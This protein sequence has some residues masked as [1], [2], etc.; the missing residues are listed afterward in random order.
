[1]KVVDKMSI[2]ALQRE[3]IGQLVKTVYEIDDG[4]I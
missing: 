1:L 3:T 4:C 2:A